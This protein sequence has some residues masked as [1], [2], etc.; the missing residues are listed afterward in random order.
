ME[1]VGVVAAVPGLIQIIQA[2]ITAVRG[3]SKKDVAPKVA[4]NLI[5]SLQNV[6]Q[7]LERGKEQ[8]LWTKPQFEQHKSTIKQWTTELASLKLV[9]QPSNIKKETRRSLK[10]FYLVLT[11]LEKTLN[12]WSTRLSN[13]QTELILIMTHIQQETMKDLLHETV[14]SRLRADLHPCSDSFIPDKTPGTCEW[15]W[16]QSTF[17]DWIK[18]SPTMPDSYLK[19]TLCIYGMK[20]CGKSVL[21]KSIAQK[22]GDQ[23]QIALHFSFWSGD[24]NQR[25]LQDLLRTLVWQTLRR[26]KDADL[27]KVSKL[28]TRSD[29][30]DK[31]SLVEALRIALS[32]ISQKVYC[33]IDGIDESSEDWNCSTDGCLS[34]VLDLVK[35]HTNLHVLL[36]GR[37][38][39]L[40]TFLKRAGPRLEI[41]EHLI[42]GDIEKLIAAEIH[43]SLESYSEAIRDEARKSLEAKTQV[44]FLW[45][46][47]VL[48]ELRRCSSVEDVRQTLQQV[49]HDLDREYHRLLLQLMIRT[50]GSL[51]KPSISM[52]R[53]RYLLWSILACPEPMTGEDLCYAYA[54]QANVNGTIEDD[55]ITTDGVM[56]ACGDFVRAT[57]GRYHIIHASASEFLMRP[58]NDWEAED[59][60]ISYFQVNLT[61]AQGSMSLACFKYIRSIDLGYPLTDGGASSLPSRYTFFSYVARYLPFHLAEGLQENEHVGLETSKFVRTHHFCALIE[62]LLATSQNPTHTGFLESMY[63]WGEIFAATWMQLDQAFKLELDRRER[64]FG[65]QDERYQSWLGLACLMPENAWKSSEPQIS[66]SNRFTQNRS[67]TIKMKSNA[68]S[69]L[70]RQIGKSHLPVIQR[71]S[72]SL[73]AFSQVLTTFRTTC[74]DLLASSLES[75]PVPMLLLAGKVATKQRNR[76]LAEKIGVISVKKTTGKADIFELCSLMLLGSVR[77]YSNKDISDENEVLVRESVRIANCLPTQPHVQMLKVEAL[78]ILILML[79]QK[80]RKQDA[81]E[82]IR[83]FED[84]IGRHRKKSSSPVWE[85]GLRHTRL[86]TVQRTD[87]F[88]RMAERLLFT[89]NYT[90]SA[91]FAAQAIEILTDSK[92]EPEDRDLRLLGIHRDALYGTGNFDECISSCQQL[93]DF[94]NKL[95]SGP[96]VTNSRWQTQILLARCLAE[97]G[98]MAEANTWL[99]KADDEIELL[100][101]DEHRE[102]SQSWMMFTLDDLALMGRYRLCQSMVLELLEAKQTPHSNAGE[103]LEFG[104]LHSLVSNLKSIGCIDPCYPE[105]LRCHSLLMMA[106]GVRDMVGKV[107]W[108]GERL[109]S[110]YDDLDCFNKRIPVLKLKYIDTCLHF[111]DG[112][113]NAIEGYITLGRF[114]FKQGNIEAADLVSSDA[115]SH[116]FSD[117]SSD[118]P[119]WTFRVASQVYL[120]A[121]KFSKCI[122]L[123]C[124]AY[125]ESLNANGDAVFSFEMEMV[126]ALTYILGLEDLEEDLEKID[127]R[128]SF[129]EKS[130]EHLAKASRA[131]DEIDRS[132]GSGAQEEPRDGDRDAEESRKERMADLKA[133]LE[134]L[135]VGSML[136]E[137]VARLGSVAPGA[138]V[139]SEDTS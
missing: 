112:L 9:L 117:I 125:E 52:T 70:P 132:K 3:V 89:G 138:E 113:S 96:M 19:R 54:T 60:D 57:G 75:M 36:A 131:R 97:Q 106:K 115:A 33:T 62:Y 8:G 118:D 101:P 116:I 68:I 28:L 93:L 30:I 95:A 80:E 88:G 129:L 45:V 24:E 53:A 18:S 25:K 49:P 7:I 107:D 85:Y 103:D 26:I 110:I 81:D 128:L 51:A 63:Y 136:T 41:T 66:P 22:L 15:I 47:L 6:E 126:Y 56:D 82:F 104:P 37:E 34:T 98:N 4:Q 137:A 32:G 122:P 124:Q 20:G 39:S 87:N 127:L 139:S 83:M 73:Q 14:T 86:G 29:G 55:L 67:V 90:V 123:L 46:T 10:K 102:R 92:S 109:W 100:G 78:Q 69:L 38:A 120:Y 59:T 61:E 12:A 71:V 35:N 134:D 133:R 99:S 43:D 13:I 27:E 65:P 77:Y 42:R 105:F 23:G 119:S 130:C 50:K 48:K 121:G 111:E 79:L 58:K 40:R 31:R 114:F 64:D 94:S 11:E 5:Q 44:M 76:L 16:S 17:S 1:V 108:F 84:L 74:T 91:D 21:I 135:N 2:V 72:G